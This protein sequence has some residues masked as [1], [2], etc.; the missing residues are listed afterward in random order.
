V[1]NKKLRPIIL[2]GGSGKRLWPLS[3]KEKPKQFISIFGDLS[4]FDLSLQRVNKG[5]LFKKPIIVTSIDYLKFVEDSITRTGVEPEKIIL[6]PFSKNTFPAISLT[7]LI[8]LLKNKNESFMVT[9]SDHYISNNKEFH[10]SCKLAKGNVENGGLILFG[11]KPDRASTEYGY[12][13]ALNLEEEF[14][15]VKEFIEKPSS[16]AVKKVLNKPNVLWN[17]GIFVFNGSWFLKAC[18]EI[19]KQAFSEI[20]AITPRQYPSSLFFRPKK[21]RFKALSSYPF[22]KK[23]VEKNNANYVIPLSVDW[24]DLGSWVSLSELQKDRESELTLFSENRFKRE[25]RPWGFFEVLMETDSSKVK[26]I[27]VSVG[28]KLSLQKHK[29][30]SETWYVVQGKAKVTKGN[31]RF[32]LLNGDSIIIHK[33]EE[34]RLENISNEPLEIIEIQTGTYFG[35]DDIIRLK[36]SYGR[37]GL[38]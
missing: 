22:D 10:D 25:K 15:E 19:D 16:E 12:I 11:V 36:D 32:T 7:V 27:S 9:P 29:Y 3:T 34:H 33:N 14:N 28:H 30:R 6:E 18:K 24:S 8:S 23:F 2:A 26:L 38:H 17:A 4:L 37:A 5:S 13:Q 1:N 20:E 35:E 21:K 31:E